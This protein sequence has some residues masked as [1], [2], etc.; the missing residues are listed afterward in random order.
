M[1]NHAAMYLETYPIHHKLTV[2]N[3]FDI[4]AMSV[5]GVILGDIINKLQSA[6]PDH[7]FIC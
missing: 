2:D 3:K 7:A 1:Y 4:K 6:N 5:A